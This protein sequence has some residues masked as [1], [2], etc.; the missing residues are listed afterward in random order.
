[1]KILVIKLSVKQKSAAAHQLTQKTDQLCLPILSKL[2]E[3][4]E[5]T[6]GAFL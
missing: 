6:K 4:C 1:M 2:V 3:I 5:A